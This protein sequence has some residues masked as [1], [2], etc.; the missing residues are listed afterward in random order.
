[1]TLFQFDDNFTKVS[2][3]HTFKFGAQFIR[4][5]F[6]GFSAFPTRGS[7]TFN[8]QYTRQIGSSTAATS[9]ADFALG[10]PSGVT[11][12]IL[13]GEFGMR[14]WTLGGFRTRFLARHQSSHPDFGTALRNLSASLRCS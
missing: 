11:R 4:D 9:L 8:G 7:Y 1:M 5:R 2:G 13:E 12:N 6:N 10:A 14:F 3:K